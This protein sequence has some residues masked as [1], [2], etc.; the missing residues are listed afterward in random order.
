MVP[1]LELN[2]V[3][4]LVLKHSLQRSIV[5]SVALAHPTLIVRIHID[6]LHFLYEV[7]AYLTDQRVNIIFL[8]GLRVEK[9]KRDVFVA[10]WVLN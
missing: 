8:E 9:P 2:L 7:T 1:N 6:A 4:L 10:D 3:N 5:D